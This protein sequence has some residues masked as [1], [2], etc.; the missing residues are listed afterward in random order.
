[1]RKAPTPKPIE[2]E[3]EP[4]PRRQLAA[5]LFSGMSPLDCSMQF[6]VSV[7]YAKRILKELVPEMEAKY[8]APGTY[9]EVPDLIDTYVK[10]TLESLV[11][12]TKLFSD[13]DW[14]RKQA[15]SD[16]ALLHGVL[17]DRAIYLLGAAERAKA[18]GPPRD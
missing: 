1:M 11:A 10:G 7:R 15:A 8:R 12:Q 3:L 6:G 9:G 18:L 13:P 16:L 2:H 4:E 17:A 14:L 5:A